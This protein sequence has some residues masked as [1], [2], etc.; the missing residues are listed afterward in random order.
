VSTPVL[1]RTIA[2]L[3]ILAP[4]VHLAGTSRVA[5]ERGY[6]SALRSLGL[7]LL[8]LDAAEPNVRDYPFGAESAQWARAVAEHRGRIERVA[9]V[10]QEIGALLASV[11]G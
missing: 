10:Y 4:T 6:L 8:D 3:G 9:S 11:E 1:D 7:A 5:L 2:D